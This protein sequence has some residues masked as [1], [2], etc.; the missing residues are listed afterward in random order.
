MANL[1]CLLVWTFGKFFA[2]FLIAEHTAN[3]IDFG[4]EP[5]DKGYQSEA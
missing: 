4:D 5:E 3:N 1:G 2:H